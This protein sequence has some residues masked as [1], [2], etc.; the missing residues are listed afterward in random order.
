M[1]GR[2]LLLPQ[3]LEPKNGENK[4]L[5]VSFVV[6][7]TTNFKIFSTLKRE[8]EQ[9]VFFEV[10]FGAKDPC[11]SCTYNKIP[12]LSFISNHPSRLNNLCVN[13][14]SQILSRC[15]LQLQQSLQLWTKLCLALFTI[16]KSQIFV[17]YLVYYIYKGPKDIFLIAF[18]IK[19]NAVE[20]HLLERCARSPSFIF[21]K[22]LWPDC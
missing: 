22:Q 14:M 3:N 16:L 18:S 7:V 6:R 4:T 13:K 12:I 17:P 21:N 8:T 11:H 2:V 1:Q 20:W 15:L 9:L 19:F 10:S 5:T